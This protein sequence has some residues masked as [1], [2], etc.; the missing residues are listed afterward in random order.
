MPPPSLPV[1]ETAPD[2]PLRD[3]QTGALRPGGRSL[4]P[5]GR[6]KAHRNYLKQLI[7]EHG[8]KAYDYLAAVMNGEIAIDVLAREPGPHEDAM[9]AA[10]IPVVRKV[11]TIRER[12]DAAQILA[13]HLNGKPAVS[14][15]A[16]VTHEHSHRVDVRRLSDA[17]LER[18]ESLL[19]AAEV[20]EGEIVDVEPLAPPE[21]LALLE[22]DAASSPVPVAQPAAI[23]RPLEEWEI[24]T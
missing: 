11:P 2:R 9:S 7:G 24:P 20:A 23:V 17:D 13:E 4:N 15:E 21:P 10:L 12:M 18:L 8:E 16:D 3:P 19:A 22:P 5:S 1:S 6:R 14:I